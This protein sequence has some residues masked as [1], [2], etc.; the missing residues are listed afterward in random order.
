[1][2]TERAVQY[3]WVISQVSVDKKSGVNSY[4]GDADNIFFKIPSLPSQNGHYYK[5]S[6]DMSVRKGTLLYVTY[7]SVN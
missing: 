2:S 1:M 7:G 5:K 6:S 4:L 3:P